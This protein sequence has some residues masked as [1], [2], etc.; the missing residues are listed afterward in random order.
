MMMR[1]GWEPRFSSFLPVGAKGAQESVLAVEEAEALRLADAE[2]LTQDEC[3]KKM[4][5]SQPTFS[6]LVAEARRKSALAIT[7]GMAISIRGGNY[8]DQKGV[9]KMDGSGR[10]VRANRGRGGCSPPQDAGTRSGVGFGRGGGRGRG[11]RGRGGGFGRGYYPAAPAQ[12]P[13]QSGGLEAR[14]DAL[15][16]KM[17]AIGSK[18][19]RLLLKKE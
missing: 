4:K 5:V 1:V 7:G 9:P 11:C 6:R 2:G 8:M 10:G 18:L 14:M 17:E 16:G 19:D 12:Q 13:A 15:E 3:A